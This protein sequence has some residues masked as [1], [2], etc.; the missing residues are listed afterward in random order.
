MLVN[1]QVRGSEKSVEQF[2]AA[3]RM[4][5]EAW[6]AKP[7]D[8]LIACVFTPTREL[9]RG[10]VLRRVTFHRAPGGLTA[11]SLEQVCVD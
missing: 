9:C 1:L 6:F 5:L 8:N 7:D 3:K 10:G 11:E 4:E 2:L